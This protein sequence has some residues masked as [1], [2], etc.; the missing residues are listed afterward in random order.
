[1]DEAKENPLRKEEIELRCEE[2]GIEELFWSYIR[3]QRRVDDLEATL[4]RVFAAI[5]ETQSLEQL[6]E[7][8]AIGDQIET[9][10]VHRRLAS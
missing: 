5:A 2:L 8:V 3:L 10:K 9:I 4:G 7:A 6:R 1:M